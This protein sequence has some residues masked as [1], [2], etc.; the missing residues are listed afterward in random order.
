MNST[1]AWNKH[2]Y[3]VLQDPLLITICKRF[4]TLQIRKRVFQKCLHLRM[5]REF[6]LSGVN[7]ML[8][9]GDAVAAGALNLLLTISIINTKHLRMVNGSMPMLTR[10]IPR[11]YVRREADHWGSLLGVPPQALGHKL[12]RC[13][14]RLLGKHPTEREPPR[15]CNS[16]SPFFGLRTWDWMGIGWGLDGPGDMSSWLERQW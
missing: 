3:F 12:C 16:G 4:S 7:E 1:F 2:L 14:A 8:A 9:H 5:H 13:D 15:S 11:S 6:L 10:N